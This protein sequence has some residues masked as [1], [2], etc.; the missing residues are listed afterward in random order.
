MQKLDTSE[1][2]RALAALRRKEPKPCAWC[3][4]GFEDYR[5]VRYCGLPCKQAAYRDRHREELAARRQERRRRQ[6]QDPRGV[7]VNAR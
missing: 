1:A 6:K 3:G 5:H 2:A 4:R 7:R